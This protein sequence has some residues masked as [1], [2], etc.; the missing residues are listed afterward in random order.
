VLL[1]DSAVHQW[2]LLCKLDGAIIR[3]SWISKAR[4]CLKKVTNQG[5]M[6]SI[7]AE[8]AKQ[9]KDC[10]DAALFSFKA[11]YP[12]VTVV[13]YVRDDGGPAR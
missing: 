12:F 1:R 7:S 9:S 6:G 2:A 3:K 4:W 13:A 11:C 5:V 8:R 10:S